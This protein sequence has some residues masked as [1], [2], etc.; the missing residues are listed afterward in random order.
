MELRAIGCWKPDMR[1]GIKV[2]E[3]AADHIL[4]PGTWPEKRDKSAPHKYTLAFD[5][6]LVRWA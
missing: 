1:C 4:L 2:K 6:K 3:T 5:G